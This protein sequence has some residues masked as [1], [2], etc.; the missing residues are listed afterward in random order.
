MK[1]ARVGTTLLLA[2][3]LLTAA[4]FVDAKTNALLLCLATI[5]VSYVGF[6]LADRIK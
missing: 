5:A 6:H 2:A 3:G 1:T 4:W